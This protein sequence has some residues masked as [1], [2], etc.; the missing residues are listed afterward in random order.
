MKFCSRKWKFGRTNHT[1]GEDYYV[2]DIK[3]RGWLDTP[4]K[5]EYY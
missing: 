5:K 2:N 3:L 4:S 1:N